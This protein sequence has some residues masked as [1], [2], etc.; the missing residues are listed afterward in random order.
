MRAARRMRG[1]GTSV[2]LKNWLLLGDERAIRAAEI[3]GL[4]ADRLRFGFGFDRLVDAHVPFL[5]QGLLGD[6]VRE[7]RA[8]R[9]IVGESLGLGEH[10]PRRAQPV[11]E[12]PALAF[13]RTH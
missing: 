10:A 5:V 1:W 12:A 8:A 6:A 9:E 7:G 13:I 4:H 2:P 3:L 11:E